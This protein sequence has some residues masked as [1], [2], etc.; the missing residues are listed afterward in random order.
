MAVDA[1]RKDFNRIFLLE[2]V[3]QLAELLRAVGSPVA[4]IEYQDNIFLAAKV[5]Q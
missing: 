1:H 5:G 4:T 3:F 2:Q